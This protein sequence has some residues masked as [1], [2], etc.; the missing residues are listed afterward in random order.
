MSHFLLSQF[1]FDLFLFEESI[2]SNEESKISKLRKIALDPVEIQGAIISTNLGSGSLVSTK[3]N[4]KIKRKK[5]ETK[6]ARVEYI[7]SLKKGKCELWMIRN[8]ELI[9]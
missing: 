5:D 1:I 2:K 3:V 8:F 4:L 9:E 7:F 6:K